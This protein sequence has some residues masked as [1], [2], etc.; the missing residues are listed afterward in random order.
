MKVISKG[1]R[2]QNEE[3]HE[4]KG[5]GSSG[6][7]WLGHIL[8]IA[9][10]TGARSVLDY[11][12][13]K[14]TLGPYIERYG[15]SYTPYDPA[16]HPAMPTGL[17]DLVVCLD[18]LEHIEP[19]MLDTVL[20]HMYSLTGGVLFAV[21]S[22]RPSSKTL[23][24]GRNAHLITEEWPFW[25]QHLHDGPYWRGVRTREHHDHF[26][27][28]GRAMAPRGIPKSAIQKLRGK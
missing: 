23:S 25:R 18:V 28:V 13:G 14:A 22:T 21:V 15:L 2:K 24:D 16:T 6:H 10:A 9:D 19:D 8:E 1:Y 5:Y 20:R 4:A 3:L 12:A 27:Y 26:S 17:F 11:G 7:L